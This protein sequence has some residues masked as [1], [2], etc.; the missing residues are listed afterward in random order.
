MDPMNYNIHC[1][2]K[3]PLLPFLLFCDEEF[4]VLQDMGMFCCQCSI[5]QEKIM[6]MEEIWFFLIEFVSLFHINFCNRMSEG[7]IFNLTEE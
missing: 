1:C 7:S 6:L 3:S 4:I 2:D 5:S